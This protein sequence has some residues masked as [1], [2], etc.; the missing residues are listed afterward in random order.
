[1]SAREDLAH[2]W[3]ARKDPQ[4]IQE[5]YDERKAELMNE[6]ILQ[7]IK[8]QAGQA[9]SELERARSDFGSLITRVNGALDDSRS[10]YVSLA[11]LRSDIDAAERGIGLAKARLETLRVAVNQL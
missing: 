3:A 5:A 2:A 4:A 1:M 6:E 11:A 9:M 8:T 7:G 10:E